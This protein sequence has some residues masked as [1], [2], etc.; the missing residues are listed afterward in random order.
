MT[1]FL[2]IT[3]NQWHAVLATLT[4]FIVFSVVWFVTPGLLPDAWRAVIGYALGVWVAVFLQA[5]NECIQT[6]DPKLELKYGSWIRFIMDSRDDWRM[7][8][9]GVAFSVPVIGV[10]LIILTWGF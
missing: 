10:W 3:Y 7:F 9:L 6:L 5:V 4:I 2:G 1:R 8:W